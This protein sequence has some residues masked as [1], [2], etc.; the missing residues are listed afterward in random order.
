MSQSMME[1]MYVKYARVLTVTEF[2]RSSELSV[3]EGLQ[4]RICDDSNR[5]ANSS[6]IDGLE[7]LST[8]LSY[9]LSFDYLAKPGS[10]I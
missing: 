1:S 2:I 5:V 3:A 10:N 4:N 8:V 9:C 6:C 7:F